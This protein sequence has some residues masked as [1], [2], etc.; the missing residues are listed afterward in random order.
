M[1]IRKLC[2]DLVNNVK[3]NA[4]DMSD[5]SKLVFRFMDCNY[6]GVVYTCPMNLGE[7]MMRGLGNEGGCP[8]KM[9]PRHKDDKVAAQDWMDSYGDG[10]IG[11]ER[12]APDF[13]AEESETPT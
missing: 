6:P 4:F 5:E 1:P 13:W 8:S 3:C 12:E 2:A 9:E 10:R 7:A 11:V